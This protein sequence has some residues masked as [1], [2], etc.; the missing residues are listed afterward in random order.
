MK[1][2]TTIDNSICKY[3]DL[4]DTYR[5]V[6]LSFTPT[7]DN[8]TYTDSTFKQIMSL[9]GDKSEETIKDFVDRLRK[10]EYIKIETYQTEYQV[11]RN[12]YYMKPL[13]KNY[14][15]ISNE[16]IGMDLSI[17]HK[18]FLIQL[19]GLCINLTN[20]TEFTNKEIAARLGLSENTI[21]TYTKKLVE[22]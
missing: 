8:N 4:K 17:A 21:S 14:R 5:Y 1:T 12:K 19:F 22:L 10:S 2:Y 9:T 13:E 11:K 20:R 16:I 3:L 7:K 6:C 15:R 18:G